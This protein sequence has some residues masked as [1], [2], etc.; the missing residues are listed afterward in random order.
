[1]VAINL[2]GYLV[3]VSADPTLRVLGR[4]EEYV[5]NGT[6]SAG[7]KTCRV[8]RGIFGWGNSA[9]T[10]AVSDAHIG[11]IVFAVD[12]Q[13]VALRNPTGTYPVAGRVYDVD[14]DGS[15]FIE[16][17]VQN[18]QHGGL[19]TSSCSPGLTCRPRARTAS[20]RS[21]ARA[22]WCSPPRPAWSLWACCSTRRP[23]APWPSCA[24]AA[25]CGCSWRTAAPR[26]CWS[27]SPSPRAAPRPRSITTC[28][29]SGA[30]P[31]LPSPA[32][33][34][35]ARCSRRAP[36]R[37]TSRSSTSIRWAAARHPGLSRTH[38]KDYDH[39]DHPAV[40]ARPPVAINQL[41]QGARTKTPSVYQQFASRTTAATKTVSFP[42]AA[43]RKLRR[44]DGER[45]V[46]NGKAYDYRVTA[47][48][49]ELTMGIPVEEI[50][51]D[52]IGAYNHLV[53]DMGEQTA[54]WPDD[55][56]FEALLAGE[57]ELAFD[58][59]PFFSNS[60]ALKSGSAIDNLH[61]STALTKDNVAAII[62][63]MMGYVGEDRR[64]LRVRPN[65]LVVPPVAPGGRPRD[66]GRQHP[67]AGVRQQHRRGR[68]HQH[69]AGPPPAG[70]VPR[71]RRERGRVG[72][73]LV[74]HGHHPQREALGLRRA[75]RA[76]MT[77]KNAASDD[78][79]FWDDEVVF[80]VR[81]RGA[82]GY[83]PFWLASKCIA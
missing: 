19:T 5:D 76:E 1:M 12:N 65:L 40:S 69:D 56:V 21:T 41:F 70:R 64:S 3:E 49:F 80:G 74:P 55:L 9:T 15:V 53:M 63:L 24:A 38:P 23:R 7:D 47:E 45:K 54:L 30:R 28:D 33:S 10:L 60:H 6:G 61:A 59:L 36:A 58:G 83:R 62:E 82:A 4:A 27:P 52:N 78:N 22:T 42:H 25:G 77:F 39:A 31:R 79:V 37:V 8:K 73:D 29:A 51:D 26:A 71:A 48:K 32:A 18:D 50:E 11:R 67:R 43:T 75:Q 17:G 20:S 35:W 46:V 68:H 13:T 16:H 2:S 66:R 34:S 57:T 44:W 72:F 14:A 81:A